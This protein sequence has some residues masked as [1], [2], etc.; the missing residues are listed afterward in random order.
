ME[1]ITITKKDEIKVLDKN[2]NDKNGNENVNQQDN[3]ISNQCRK[4]H[5]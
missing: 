2:D 3:T 5:C 4:K 1:K